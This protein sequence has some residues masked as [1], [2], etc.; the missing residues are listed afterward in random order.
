MADQKFFVPWIAFEQIDFVGTE[1]LK[2]TSPTIFRNDTDQ[3]IH[4]DRVLL[5]P[6]SVT[7]VNVRYGL[8]DRGEINS[9]FV[10]ID[11]LHNVTHIM[12]QSTD[13]Q[14]PVL[15]FRK[16]VLVPPKQVFLVTLHDVVAGGTRVANVQFHGYRLRSPSEPVIFTGR[17]AIPS[18]GQV[19][20]SVKTDHVSP[21]VLTSCAL[22]LEESGTAAKLRGLKIAVSGG[23]LPAWTNT[24]ARASVVFPDINPCAAIWEPPSTFVLQPGDAFFAEFFGVGGTDRTVYIGILGYKEDRRS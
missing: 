24:P 5:D 18:G 19:S 23:G 4:I 10:R 22:F 21:V 11:A 13:G 8:R 15:I 3:P 17:A 16:P 1:G 9:G 7:D 6:N 14:R 2:E 20:L 12:N